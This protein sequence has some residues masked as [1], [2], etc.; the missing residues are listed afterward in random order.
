MRL[1]SLI[2]FLTFQVT[3]GWNMK[4]HRIVAHI[5]G[6]LIQRKTARYVQR[7]LPR[8]ARRGMTTAQSCLVKSAGWADE[9][10]DEYSWSSE[11]HFSHTPQFDCQTFEFDRDCGFDE[12]GRCIV[13]A[14]ANYTRR[15]SDATLPRSELAEAVKFL[16]HFVADSHQPLHV[17]FA[18]DFGGTHIALADPEGFDLHAAWDSHLVESHMNSI[19]ADGEMLTWFVLAERMAQHL[20]ANPELVASLRMDEPVADGMMTFAAAIVSEVSLEL[21]CYAAYQH[22]PGEWIPPSGFSLP[23]AYVT[24]RSAIAL[25]LLVRAGVRLAQVLDTV[26]AAYYVSERAVKAPAGSGSA[27]GPMETNIFVHLQFDP[28][29][30]VEDDD[31]VDVATGVPVLS[32]DD[33]MPPLVIAPDMATT[34]TVPEPV[35]RSTAEKNRLAKLRRKARDAIAARSIDGVDVES[36][37]LVRPR[38][39]Y[40]Y[41]TNIDRRHVLGTAVICRWIQFEGEE[42]PIEFFFDTEVFTGDITERVISAV[43]HKLRGLPYTASSSA[44]QAASAPAPDHRDPGDLSN[45]KLTFTHLWLNAKGL[46]PPVTSTLPRSAI[47]DLLPVSETPSALR[48]RYGGKIPSV[49][50]QN[51]DRYLG[52]KNELAFLQFGDGAM[53]LTRYDFLAD[54]TNL[55]WVFNVILIRVMTDAAEKPLY[56]DV[57]VWDGPVVPEVLTEVYIRTEIRAKRFHA[58]KTRHIPI[59]AL[60]DSFLEMQADQSDDQSRIVTVAIA[61]ESVTQVEPSPQLASDRSYLGTLE[62]RLRPGREQAAVATAV[63][64]TVPPKRPT[65]ASD[66]IRFLFLRAK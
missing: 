53:V 20:R 62:F 39:G 66:R 18:E 64:S 9:I 29:D 5:A 34:T 58:L 6:S 65:G 47:G 16:V 46:G 50:R 10:S 45:A 63:D 21:T 44:M 30:Y 60:L 17:G 1:V 55:R 26:A 13:S 51:L 38:E 40:L 48:A 22:A 59:L 49:G 33:D 8:S 32:T 7:L 3:L 31:M 23:P 43:F 19:R 37:I 57:R 61:T 35:P 12:S 2:C 41:I 24:S 52:V 25:D 36:L 15:A 42:S 56:V 27:S 11:L 54:T 28:E 4:G 14:I